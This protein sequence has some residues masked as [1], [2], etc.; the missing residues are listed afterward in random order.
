M[1]DARDGG[2]A[3]DNAGETNRAAPEAHHGPRTGH[4]PPVQRNVDLVGKLRLSDVQPGWVADVATYRD[5]AYLAGWSP[6][7]AAE[8]P[9]EAGGFWSV[10]IRNPRRPRELTFVSSP[11]GSYLTE[12]MHAMRLTTASFRGDIL[13]ASQEICGNAGPGEGEGGFSIY[14]V[15]NPAAPVRLGHGAD[16]DVRE[17]GNASH[18]VFGWDV[19]N[20]AY[21]VAVDN[22]EFEDVDI[23]DI[24]DPRNPVLIKETGIDD[25]P[26]AQ[27]NLAY[28]E[29]AFLHDV[30]VRRV[31]GHWRMLLSYWDAGYVV[32]NVDDPANP[33]FV[34]DTDFEATDPLVPD[35]GQPEGNAH[36]AEWDR[37][38]EEGVRSRFPC[39]NVRYILGADE[40]FSTARPIFEITDGD[41]AGLYG[42]GEFSWPDLTR[43]S[44]A[45]PGGVTGVTVFGG[46]GCVEDVN[47][48]GTSDR[49]EVPA[50]STITAPAGQIKIVVFE[51][52]TCFFSD[53]VSSGQLAGYDVIVIGNH[54]AGS[55]GGIFPDA[56]IC[57]SQGSDL[58][59]PARSANCIG[60]RALHLLFDDEPA[61]ETPSGTGEDLPPIGTTGATVAVQGGVF[62][63]WGYLS[64]YDADTMERLDS[65]A[66]PEALDPRYASGFGDLTVHEITTDPTGNVGY[67]AW[68]SGGFRVVDYTGGSLREVGAF[69]DP[70]GSDFWGVELNVRRDGRLFALA[71]DR[72]YGLYIF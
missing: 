35:I 55:V 25:W 62:D 54:H 60:H 3:L 33:V 59:G 20:K 44:A 31:E 16:T 14:D 1:K 19:G 32:L 48:N 2:Q 21:A 40:D 64:L 43:L 22:Q 28:G 7:C 61:Y 47:D 26:D 12:G 46:S 39:G 45:Y 57:G 70:Q 6:M 65:Y 51:R 23:F 18:S 41:N 68:Y 15:S 42:A 63:A 71:S 13:L 58:L 8:G 67:L 11:T 69:I 4:L 9:R 37:C 66:I 34:G 56:F 27:T 5:H 38:P 36:E 17:L 24:T 53:K 29:Q 30:V 10:D 72:D 52:G 50:A 49:D